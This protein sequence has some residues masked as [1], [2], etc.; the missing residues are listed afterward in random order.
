MSDGGGREA[1]RLLSS[2]GTGSREVEGTDGG[3]SEFSGLKRQRSW[4][5]GKVNL[6]EG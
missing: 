2:S 3:G 6:Y 4:E 1:D 5:H